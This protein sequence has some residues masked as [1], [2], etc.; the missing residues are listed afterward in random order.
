MRIV[1]KA[2]IMVGD[3]AGFFKPKDTVTQ[4]IADT[5]L[6]RIKGKY[7]AFKEGKG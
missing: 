5:L 6:K 7:N 2:G 3:G 1:S 4:E